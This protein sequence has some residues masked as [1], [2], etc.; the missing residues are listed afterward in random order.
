MGFKFVHFPLIKK[1]LIK[2][3][4]FQRRTVELGNNICRLWS[5]TTCL[6]QSILNYMTM[7]PL[8]PRL[9]HHE[10][11]FYLTIKL[12]V[13]PLSATFLDAAVPIRA[14][15]NISRKYWIISLYHR[16]RFCQ[17][18]WLEDGIFV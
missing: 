3:V 4:L 17:S 2:K 13:H 18:H 14:I 15:S 10:V 7:N 11:R 1:M 12:K 9:Q 6:V 8:L 16:L 5:I